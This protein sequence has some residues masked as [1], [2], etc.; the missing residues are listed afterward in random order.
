GNDWSNVRATGAAIK[1]TNGK[2]QGVIPFL[3]VANDTAVAVNQCFSPETLIYTSTGIK[4][5][6]E[7]K[8]SDLVLGVSGLYR[9]VKDKFTYNQKDSMVSLKF[10]HSVAPVS[11]TAGHPF[12]AIRG[13]PLEQSTERTMQWLSK[14]KVRSEWVD[15]GQLKTG[16]Y[17]AQVIPKEV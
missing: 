8:L 7:V 1:G 13:V 6:A 3:K 17:V 4:P 15:A 5:I 2:S 12:Y 14:G 11:V 10:K 16:D 9:P